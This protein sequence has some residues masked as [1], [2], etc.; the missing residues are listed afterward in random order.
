MI[1][2][3]FH[4][5]HFSAWSGQSG[6]VRIAGMIGRQIH[7][8][9]VHIFN[10]LRKPEDPYGAPDGE[11]L[12]PKM[13]VYRMHIGRTYTI[14]FKV[15]KELNH[16]MVLDLIATEQ[17]HKG[18]VATTE[19]AA[20][21]FFLFSMNPKPDIHFSNSRYDLE[22]RGIVQLAM[23]GPERVFDIAWFCSHL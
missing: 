19:V 11:C 8:P 3:P 22:K 10:H 5:A 6:D 7:P 21:C 9:P 13:Q 18:Y 14:I 23:G 16:V 17:A 2:C 20:F 4:P 15:Y 12:H 1:C